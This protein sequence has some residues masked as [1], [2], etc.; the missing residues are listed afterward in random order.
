M[1]TIQ[2]LTGIIFSVIL[3]LG[4]LINY[5]FII[6]N[7]NQQQ[8]Q[9]VETDEVCGDC[10][11]LIYKKAFEIKDAKKSYPSS[12]N[13]FEEGAI[14]VSCTTSETCKKKGGKC[15]VKGI[16][17]VKRGGKE[18]K[19]SFEVTDSESF[20]TKEK[21]YKNRNW[22]KLPTKETAYKALNC[23]CTGGK[24]ITKPRK[25][26]KPTKTTK[27][28]KKVVDVKKETVKKEEKKEEKEKASCG[29]CKRA[30]VL[31]TESDIKSAL[32]YGYPED[33]S[34]EG[35]FIFN[36]ESIYV[37]CQPDATCKKNKACKCVI[38]GS[39]KGK[40]VKLNTVV[41][42]FKHKKKALK[43]YRNTEWHQVPANLKSIKC[44][45]E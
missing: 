23:H 39:I 13:F 27:P 6:N 45:C 31:R 5:G 21:A 42:R 36:K 40:A 41:Y 17:V 4:L 15:I 33:R 44:S 19:E 2:N 38:R 22:H 10:V 29:T 9:I 32:K 37:G 26:T 1:K 11:R 16:K 30:V 3:I 28:T 25:P 14:Y 20:P 43:H 35:F 8:T 24:K 7:T 12:K 34:A 18:V